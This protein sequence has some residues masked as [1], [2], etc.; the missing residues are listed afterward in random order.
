MPVYSLRLVLQRVTVTEPLRGITTATYR[1]SLDYVPA[2]QIYGLVLKSLVLKRLDPKK[3]TLEVLED[4]LREKD[5]IEEV[6]PAY[7]Y[8][9]DI[10]E[11]GLAGEDLDALSPIKTIDEP[12]VLWGLV[13]IPKPIKRLLD[14]KGI[15]CERLPLTL[16]AI[17][18]SIVSNDKLIQW[19]SNICRSTKLTLGKRFRVG[20]AFDRVRRTALHGYFY[21]YQYTFTAHPHYIATIST[22]KPL[23]GLEPLLKALD[24]GYKKSI[25]NSISD[26]VLSRTRAR[27]LVRDT[28]K[29][30]SL[31]SLKTVATLGQQ[32]KLRLL[33]YAYDNSI[34]PLKRL[35]GRIVE[36]WINK[37]NNVYLEI[38]NRFYL[39]NIH[40]YTLT[41]KGSYMIL[42]YD[43]ITDVVDDIEAIY[44]EIPE[45]IV[46]VEKIADHKLLHV[47]DWERSLVLDKI[48]KSFQNLVLIP[49]LEVEN[50]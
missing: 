48:F 49:Y 9:E 41:T 20:I 43:G 28:L 46:R 34:F 5:A 30:L 19:V 33:V 44:E 7:P 40:S 36:L 26:L 29:E 24:L 31:A 6:S 47:F 38:T 8:S 12:S 22:R 42:E 27:T 21:A 35:K 4:I 37:R 13:E 10:Q 25:N 50:R 39:V 32:G 23:E 2:S 17:V 1:V 14:R 3:T 15:E 45:N 11:M 16:L 18:G